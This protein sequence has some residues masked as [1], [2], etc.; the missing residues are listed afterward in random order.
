MSESDI[1]EG[2]NVV[3][4]E[5]ENLCRSCLVET[6]SKRYFWLE[7]YYLERKFIEIYHN[8]TSLEV[9]I[10][11]GKPK[12]ICASCYDTI[13][14]FYQ[15]KTKVLECEK[16]LNEVSKRENNFPKFE[17]DLKNEVN[18]GNRVGIEIQEE[19]IEEEDNKD[20]RLLR[21][22][23]KRKLKARGVEKQHVCSVCGKKLKNYYC[24]YSHMKYVHERANYKEDQTGF[25][26]STCG[27]VYKTKS[28]LMTHQ[29][30][31]EQPK[32]FLCTIC[33]KRYS[34]KAVLE[35]H[36]KIH[37]G[38]KSFT[39]DVCKKQ[40]R[41]IS[42]YK[43]HVMIHSNEKPLSCPVCGKCFRQHAHLKTHI[44]GQHTTERPFKCTYCGKTFKLSGN[45]VVHTRIHTGETPYI[46][47]VC[48]KGFYDSSSMK[49]HRR[50]HFEKGR[51]KIKL[52]DLNLNKA[53]EVMRVLEKEK[54]NT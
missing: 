18:L 20:C 45:L 30:K 33:G 38:E 22:K 8:V 1:K 36:Q 51:K 52:E 42:T 19:T 48:S 5:G 35:N 43:T 26:C 16:L 50:G 32:P 6:D 44:R 21:Y 34:T 11:D 46:C 47:D 23:H 54:E 37:T 12:K 29:K 39:C 3:V 27:N 15:F 7:S 53:N 17:V 28:I 4:Y 2:V 31:H 41:F 9:D 25:V 14:K 10:N 13:I 24:L 49:K 40:F